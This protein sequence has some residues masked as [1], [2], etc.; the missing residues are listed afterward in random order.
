MSHNHA[1]LQYRKQFQ[2]VPSAV[3]F[4]QQYH[5][6]EKL[7]FP[8][9]FQAPVSISLHTVVCTTVYVTNDYLNLIKDA[10]TVPCYMLGGV[11]IV[12]FFPL[13][14][15][16]FCDPKAENLSSTLPENTSS[17]WYQLC[18][19]LPLCLIY[20]LVDYTKNHPSDEPVQASINLLY[21]CIN[22]NIA[23]VY[24][25]PNAH[26]AT[27]TDRALHHVTDRQEIQQSNR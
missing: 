25:Y 17:S 14:S 27:L 4:L 2:K 15:S 18:C 19:N 3:P 11:L 6:S 9:C 1:K 16:P 20:N 10:V 12:F 7:H 23:M 13:N 24:Q 5:F 8:K 22:T 21:N 26:I